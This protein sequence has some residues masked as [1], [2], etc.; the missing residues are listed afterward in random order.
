MTISN[1]AVL[2]YVASGVRLGPS[3]DLSRWFPKSFA[4]EESKVHKLPLIAGMGAAPQTGLMQNPFLPVATNPNSMRRM[5]E[6]LEASFVMRSEDALLAAG[7]TP[8]ASKLLTYYRLCICASGAYSR[9]EDFCGATA[10]LVGNA[11]APGLTVKQYDHRLFV[12]ADQSWPVLVLAAL[13]AFVDAGNRFSESAAKSAQQSWACTDWRSCLREA[14]VTWPQVF[15][16]V[17]RVFAPR[18]LIATVVHRI[19]TGSAKSCPI[20]DVATHSENDIVAFPV[21]APWAAGAAGAWWMSVRL[22]AMV[23]VLERRAIVRDLLVSTGGE[24]LPTG[25][26]TW[27]ASDLDPLVDVMRI[28]APMILG[29][30]RPIYEPPPDSALY[31]RAAPDLSLISHHAGRFASLLVAALFLQEAV[32]DPAVDYTLMPQLPADR[33]MLTYAPNLDSI[34]GLNPN[35]LTFSATVHEQGSLPMPEIPQAPM[36]MLEP[37]AQQV[38]IASLS[39]NPFADMVIEG[40]EEE[41]EAYL[42]AH[43]DEPGMGYVP[44][45]EAPHR[46]APPPPRPRAPTP[47]PIADEFPP[48]DPRV[49]RRAD[50]L[51][52]AKNKLYG[53]RYDQGYFE[54]AMDSR[55]RSTFFSQI[56]RPE[57][58]A[59]KRA[60][61]KHMEDL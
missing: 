5:K 20:M 30:V 24:Y 45:D 57:L 52:L 10:S 46:P 37:A 55:A 44:I 40:E 26:L 7:F 53:E 11:Y 17:I 58:S 33:L 18:A 14:E 12:L 19:L 60:F 41:N 25:L 28:A 59:A 27:A 49:Q 6:L 15:Q 56:W 54:E 42:D 39:T 1:D 31:S 35:R 29:M 43:M 16:Y 51:A 3:S 38:P 4:T 34:P 2:S 50:A 23:E 47:Q 32:E 21:S 9:E 61:D 48:L 36:A 8:Q 13:G 22:A